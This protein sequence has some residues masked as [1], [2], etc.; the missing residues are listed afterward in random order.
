M[1]PHYCIQNVKDGI[2]IQV[3][4]INN[5]MVNHFGQFIVANVKQ[6]LRKSWA[7]FREKVRKLRLR[8]NYGFL[9]K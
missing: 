4:D 3:Y 7:Q 2:Q 8:Q 5:E 9:I 6:K 1:F